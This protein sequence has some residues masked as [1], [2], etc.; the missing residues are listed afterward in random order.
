M[1]RT[2]L[3]VRVGDSLSSEEHGPLDLVR[4][5]RMAEDVLV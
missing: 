4:R 3:M 1:R 5:A 2:T